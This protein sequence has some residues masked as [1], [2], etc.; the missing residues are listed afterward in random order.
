MAR[1]NVGGDNETM[2]N[3]VVDPPVRKDAAGTTKKVFVLYGTA[4]CLFVLLIVWCTVARQDWMPGH[5]V[6][7]YAVLQLHPISVRHLIPLVVG[8]VYLVA[9]RR[10]RGPGTPLWLIL[11]VLVTTSVLLDLAVASMNSGYREVAAPFERYGLEYYGDVPFVRNP[12]QFLREFTE[13]RPHMSMHARTHPPGPILL[14]WTL[15][16]VTGG[17]LLVV[18]TC[19]V[20]L[21]SLTVVPM[22]MFTRDL[23][24]REAALTCA[25]IYVVVPTTVLYNA[26]SMNAVYALFAVT[27]VWLFYRAMDGDRLIYAPL[28][29]L[30]F[31]LTL[32]M[33]YDMANLGTFFAAMFFLSV[34]DPARTRKTLRATGLMLASF[35]TFYVV[36]YFTTGFNVVTSVA[37]A[38]GQVRE[39]L[40]F[41]ELYTPRASYWV[42][43]FG[44]P[45]EMLFFAGVPVTA[46]FFAE[47]TARLRTGAWRSRIDRYLIAG[48]AMLVVFN[49]TYLGK[50][51]MARVSGFFLPF[52]IV[53]AALY[54]DRAVRQSGSTMSVTVSIGL[55]L[56]QTWLMETLLY[57]YW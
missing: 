34:F 57:I 37:A 16:L 4:A 11:A 51:E 25:S 41:M 9:L 40:F 45:V 18:A 48:L 21:A 47:W 29:G 49:F 2:A 5:V 53:P 44:N 20:A 31:A 43:R 14:L 27:A 6:P 10:I 55:L 26:T 13:L 42:W 19:V 23:A 56:V 36:L 32:F 8:A 15:S 30:T 38:V 39:D 46:L 12:V 3:D 52:I 28:M 54:L 22:Y 17:N 50:S 24:G 1:V 35:I 33:S 7:L